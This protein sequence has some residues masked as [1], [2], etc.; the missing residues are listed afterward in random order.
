MSQ[1]QQLEH[2]DS[3]SSQDPHAE[4]KKKTKSRRPA[5][6]RHYACRQRNMTL[7]MIQTLLSG[8]SD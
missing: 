4:E 6:E 8:N 1:T 7:M 3:I 5:S 2:S